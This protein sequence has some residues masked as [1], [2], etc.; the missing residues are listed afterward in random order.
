MLWVVMVVSSGQC[1]VAG[2]DVQCLSG[3]RVQGQ[4]GRRRECLLVQ[5]NGL[6]L[7]TVGLQYTL[8]YRRVQVQPSPVDLSKAAA[9]VRW[10][11]GATMV[12]A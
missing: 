1:R 3:R 4:S 5:R 6:V 12:D 11:T 7:R 10:E 9:C 2:G 8:S